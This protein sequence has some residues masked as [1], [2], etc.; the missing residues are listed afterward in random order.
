M[1][2]VISQ[3]M[4]MSKERLSEYLD[5]YPLVQAITLKQYIDDARKKLH[6]AMGIMRETDVSDSA[7]TEV[8]SKYDKYTK[9]SKN[10]GLFIEDNWGVR[11][12]DEDF[13]RKH[14]PSQC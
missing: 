13:I 7:V 3:A 10:Y 4:Q 11:W 5:D 6:D 9:I 8:Q 2:G 12:Q 1:K 14:I